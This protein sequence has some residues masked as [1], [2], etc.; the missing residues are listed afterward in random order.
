MAKKL[1]KEKLGKY[2]LEKEK[3]KT[4]EKKMRKGVP[5][6]IPKWQ[7][8]TNFLLHANSIRAPF[9]KTILC[10]ATIPRNM[11]PTPIQMKATCHMI[12]LSSLMGNNRVLCNN[13]VRHAIHGQ[14]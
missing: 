1:Q 9:F 13:K 7:P 12:P 2:M 8:P 3:K 14:M 4:R 11:H 6:K 5:K 10:G